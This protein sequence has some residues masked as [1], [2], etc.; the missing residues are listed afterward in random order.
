M[1][2]WLLILIVLL[3]VGYIY[4][5]INTFY[6]LAIME[7]YDKHL[8]RALKDPNFVEKYSHY[9]FYYVRQK[10]EFWLTADLKSITGKYTI[11]GY[12]IGIDR[13]MKN[14]GGEW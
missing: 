8:D 5:T 12:S 14:D 6:K 10:R 7:L 11:L 3:L 2:Q 13:P 9:T 1:W 4:K